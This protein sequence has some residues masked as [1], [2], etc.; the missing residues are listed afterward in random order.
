MYRKDSKWNPG[1]TAANIAAAEFYMLIFMPNRFRSFNSGHCLALFNYLK[2]TDFVRQVFKKYKGKN[3]E[4]ITF[5]ISV[6]S[7]NRFFFTF[8][9]PHIFTHIQLH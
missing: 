8:L 6:F 9:L 5:D 3:N 2:V 4:K 1:I 7:R